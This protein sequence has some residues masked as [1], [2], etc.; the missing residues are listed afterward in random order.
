[1][2][3]PGLPRGRRRRVFRRIC[4]QLMTDP[5]LSSVV[6]TW[7]IWDDAPDHAPLVTSNAPAIRLTPRLGAIGWYSPDAQAGPLEITIEANV[8]T[9]DACDCLDLWEAFELAIYPPDAAKR[10]A[11]EQD[12][13]GCPD[14]CCE[15][16][17]ITFSRPASIQSAE[18][19][20]FVMLGMMS[21]NI[22]RPFNP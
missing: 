10:N 8:D 4:Q 17:Q 15:T 3:I 20:Q 13:R 18:N 19:G 6:K 14:L 7:D 12:L 16:G 9:F 11:F 1:M 21:V 22:V 2:S 5:V